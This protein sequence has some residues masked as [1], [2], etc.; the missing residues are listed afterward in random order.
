MYVFDTDV[1]SGLL[2]GRLPDGAQERFRGLDRGKRHTTSITVGELFYG[3]LKSSA[4]TRWLKAIEGLL[5]EFT[6][7][8]FD[9]ES[10]RKYAEIR[11]SLERSGRRL[12]DPDLRIAAICAA[13]DL[14]LVSSNERHFARVPRLRH[15]NWLR[16]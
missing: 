15:E 12:D 13:R 8:D 1:L 16:R 2:R 6:C 14:I 7:L 10:A 5:P 3:A 11:S 4:T 9:A